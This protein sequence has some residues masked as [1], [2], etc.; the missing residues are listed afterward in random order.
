MRAGGE[1]RRMDEERRELPRTLNL[2]DATM[3]VVG[4]MIGAGIFLKAGAIALVLPSPWLALSVWVVAGVLSLA[5]ALT[6]AELSARYPR[7]GGLYVFLREAYGEKMG[8]CF[9]WSLLAV[10]QTG[11]IAAIAAG[12]SQ[13]IDGL[14]GISDPAQLLIALLC[15]VLLTVINVLSVRATGTVQVVFTIVKCAGILILILGGLALGHGSLTNLDGE[16]LKGGLVGAYGICMLKAL[17]AYDGWINATFV[18]GEIKRP[19]RN[20]PLA[21]AL[22]TLAVIAVY[23]AT[24]AAYHFCLPLDQIKGAKNAAVTLARFLGGE[25]AAIWMAVLV[26]VSTFGALNSSILSGPRVYFAMARDRLMFEE[27]G[28]VHV[29]FQ[30]PAF[31]ILVQCLWSM[32]LLV[33]WSKFERITDNVMFIYWL[34]YALG[35]LALFKLRARES[36]P[37]YRVPGYP[38]VPLLFVLGALYLV[39]NTIVVSPRDSAQALGLMALGALFYPLLKR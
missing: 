20:L 34:F 33:A 26:V 38:V 14:Y 29:Q 39:I 8:Y 30:T 24:N 9:G 16:V 37:G 19:E 21:L 31:S 10:M 7:S 28:A 6:M 17:W 32:L 13:G 25:N 11:S 36:G 23:V 35:G 18:A 1:P 27:M 12:V 15:I 2:L 22:G 3:V 4:S 5:G